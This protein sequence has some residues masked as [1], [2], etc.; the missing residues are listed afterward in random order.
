MKYSLSNI[1]EYSWSYKYFLEHHIDIFSS[2]ISFL[3]KDSESTIRANS[4]KLNSL[5]SQD[6]TLKHLTDEVRAQYESQIYGQ[7]EEIDYSIAE[8]YRLGVFL[9][10]FRNFEIICRDIEKDLFNNATTD[11]DGRD[12]LKKFK[13]AVEKELGIPYSKFQNEYNKVKSL[14][15]LRNYL[16]HSSGF[17]TSKEADKLG[18][19]LFNGVLVKKIDGQNAIVKIKES[20]FLK[21]ALETVCDFLYEISDQI[22]DQHKSNHNN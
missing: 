5:K 13:N 1:E 22:E 16:T 6:E 9:A 14:A 10:I 8:N 7:Y 3:I 21:E 20:L 2:A 4:K 19:L 15:L 17:I 18:P 11:N 12:F